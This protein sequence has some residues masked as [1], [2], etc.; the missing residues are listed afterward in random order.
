[1]AGPVEYIRPF[2]NPLYAW[3]SV[4]PRFARP[5]LPVMVFLIMCYF[6]DELK[7]NHMMAC[8]VPAQH[9]GEMFRLDA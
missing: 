4:G 8:E 5:K 3:A 9:M 6:A 1:M 7:S 2:L